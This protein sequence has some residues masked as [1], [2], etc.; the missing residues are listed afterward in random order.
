MVS[1]PVHQAAADAE[2]IKQG[3][4]ITAE[5][6]LSPRETERAGKGVLHLPKNPQGNRKVISTEIS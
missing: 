2:V 5:G 1:L 4:Q 6:R 3:R